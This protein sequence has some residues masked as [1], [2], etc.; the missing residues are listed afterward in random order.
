[1]VRRVAV[2]V[3]VRVWPDLSGWRCL[4]MREAGLIVGRLPEPLHPA[5]CEAGPHKFMI[6]TPIFLATSVIL[7]VTA[8][9][10]M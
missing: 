7:P 8:T 9:L 6:R 1:M 3:G 2:S 5:P 10:S 4:L